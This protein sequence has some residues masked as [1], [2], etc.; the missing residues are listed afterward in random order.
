VDAN[1]NLVDLKDDASLQDAYHMAYDSNRMTLYVDVAGQQN[2]FT[3]KFEKKRERKGKGEK[4]T[5]EGKIS[6]EEKQIMKE[7]KKKAK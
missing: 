3:D 7:Q 2:N 4:Q 1:K 5:K 6:K